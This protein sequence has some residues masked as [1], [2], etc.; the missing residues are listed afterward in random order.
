MKRLVV[1]GG[2]GSLGRAVVEKARAA[3]HDA[4]AASRTGA[5]KVDVTTGAGLDAAFV[6]AEVVV[7]STNASAGADAVLVDGTARV[8]AAAAKAGVRHFVGI[9]IVG[10]DDAPYA[11]YKTKV[12]QEKVVLASPVPWT[13]LRATQFHDLVP[14]LAAGKLGVAV[15]PRGFRLQPIDVREVADVLVAAIDAGPSQRL[16]DVGGPEIVPFIELVRAWKAAAHVRKLLLHLPVPGQLGAFLR[17]GKMCTPEHKVGKRT[18]A[19]W[20]AETYP[21]P[22]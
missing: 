10:I 22:S 7:D 1:L 5:V 12:A 18:F 6:G 11:Y 9:S 14:K 2:T 21:R 16:P 8:I 20:L 4:V 3:G 13:L 15:V 17:S 19:E